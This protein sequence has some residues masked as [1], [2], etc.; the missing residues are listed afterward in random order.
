[1]FNQVCAYF[2]NDEVEPHARGQ[3]QYHF[4]SLLSSPIVMCVLYTSLEAASFLNSR[5]YRRLRGLFTTLYVVYRVPG[6]KN[7]DNCCNAGPLVAAK[8]VVSYRLVFCRRA[9]SS[10]SRRFSNEQVT[11]TM[12]ASSPLA[13]TRLGQRLVSPTGRLS[14]VTVNFLHAAC[15]TRL[16]ILLWQPV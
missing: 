11:S 16:T 9:A 3:V 1:M 4:G 14:C 12:M 15:F 5:R 6:A 8:Q 2:W 13:R 7:T 10:A